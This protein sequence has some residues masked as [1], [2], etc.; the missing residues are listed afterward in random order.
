MS[1]CLQAEGVAFAYES[2]ADVFHDV[3]AAVA[4]GGVTGIVGPNGSGKSTL[5]RVLCGLLK[6]H[7]GRVLLDGAMLDGLS[8]IERA[9]VVGFLPQSVDP[10]FALSAFEVVCLGRYPRA[11]PLAGL[12][13][14]DKEVAARCMR[15]TET[16]GL[17]DRDFSTLSGG[18]RQR[19]LLASILAQ[20]PE[21]LLLD[22]PTSALDIH[23]QVHIFVL[24]RQLA[25]EG[26]GC[27]RGNARPEPRRAIL[28]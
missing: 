17:R 19:V 10:V 24:L 8:S 22:E 9:R 13:P 28:R 21:L 1:R 14:H 5:L 3:S 2:G 27:R 15:D 16:E 7:A 26:Y 12:R 18:E 11:G 23:H 25:A 6:P 20:E 4:S